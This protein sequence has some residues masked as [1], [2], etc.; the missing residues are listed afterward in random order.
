[1]VAPQAPHGASIA[2]LTPTDQSAVLA[3][4]A[5]VSGVEP[6]GSLLRLRERPRAP[7]MRVRRPR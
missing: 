7:E 4:L 5:E 3:W 2:D 1:V 6:D